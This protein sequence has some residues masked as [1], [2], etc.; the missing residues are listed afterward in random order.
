MI[1]TRMASSVSA[2]VNSPDHT[3]NKKLMVRGLFYSKPHL[4]A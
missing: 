4:V 2:E 1:L 3:L